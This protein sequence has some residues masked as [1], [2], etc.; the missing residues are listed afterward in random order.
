LPGYKLT[1]TDVGATARKD[2]ALEVFKA[3]AIYVTAPVASTKEMFDEL[4]QFIEDSRINAI[5]LNVQ[6]D[7]SEWVYDTQNPAVLE[8][9]NHDKILPHMPEIV[10]GLKDRG[11]YTIARI[12]TFQQPTMAKARPDLAVK[13]SASGGVWIG[14]EL[15]QQAWL[16][17]SRPE[18]HDHILD[19]TREVLTLGFDEIQYDYV[20]F[21]SDPAPGEEGKPVFSQPLTWTLKAQSIGDFLKKAH[22]VTEASDAFMSIDLHPL[23]GQRGRAAKRRYR[24]GLG[25]PGGPRRLHLPDDLPVALHRRRAGVQS[26]GRLRL[27]V[28]E[29]VGRVRLATLRGQEGQIPSMAAGLRLV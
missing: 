29:E 13:S 6:N 8:A 21:P 17:A 25:V 5:V 11:I 9:E 26:A 4:I 24:A 3:E 28:S 12:S 2:V 1:K 15:S 23:A 22:A 19:M 16:D 14:G 20:R 18:V 7:N 10:K 27:R